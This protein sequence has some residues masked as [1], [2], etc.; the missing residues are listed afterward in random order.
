MFWL[1]LAVELVP[2]WSTRYFPSQDGPA[3]LQNAQMLERWFSAGGGV[4]RSFYYLNPRPVPNWLGHLVMAGLMSVLPVLIAEKILISG[5][6]LLLP[7]SMRYALRIINRS[8]E[9]A[10]ILVMPLLY[11]SLLHMGFYNFCYGLG[12]YLLAL[13]YWLRHRDDLSGRRAVVLSMLMLGLYFA[14]LFCLLALW[15]TLAAFVAG[16]NCQLGAC[17]RRKEMA[18]KDAIAHGRKLLL[19]TLLATTPTLVFLNWLIIWQLVSPVPTP[20][21][22]PFTGAPLGPP[23]PAL[24]MNPIKVALDLPR[25]MVS[26]GRVEIWPAAMFLGLLGIAVLVIAINR[27]RR[28]AANRWDLLMIVAGGFAVIAIGATDA[29]AREFVVRPR[30][31]LLVCLLVVMWI[32]AQELRRTWRVVLGTGAVAAALAF[33]VI[34]TIEYQRLSR[35]VQAYVSLG[36][37]RGREDGAATVHGRWVGY[38]RRRAHIGAGFAPGARQ[39]LHRSGT[40]LPRS[41]QLRS[42]Y[43]S[44]SGAVPPGHE[45]LRH[46]RARDRASAAMRSVG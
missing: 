1:M 26:F 40:S 10:A 12:L 22:K 31:E 13:G 5:Y 2:L 17:V 41:D 25:V 27:I 29:R 37:D 46:P 7:L 23:L 20:G 19:R 9:W 43:R 18:G 16:V 3:H 36:E 39:R 14:H 33:C 28:R 4:W 21:L 45:S 32:G 35:D 24:S 11:H 8:A 38:G 15:V 44:F 30:C 34:Y 6:L 42:K